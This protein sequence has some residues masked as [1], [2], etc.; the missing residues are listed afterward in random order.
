MTTENR[1]V[2]FEKQGNICIITHNRPEAMN[3]H[4]YQATYEEA[5]AYTEF[6][7]D[8]DLRVAIVTG[9]GDRAFS[10]GGDLKERA[11]DYESFLK[12]GRVHNP[13][14]TLNKPVIAAVNGLAHGG[15]FEEALGCDIIV[16]AEH[17]EF[18]L[19]E[20]LRGIV[21]GAGIHHLPRVMPF[22]QAMSYLLTCKPITAQEAL[23][24]GIVSEVV[25]QRGAHGLRNEMGQRH[26]GVGASG[27]VEHQILRPAGNEHDHRRGNGA[28]QQPVGH[29]VRGRR[30][31]A[32]GLCGEAQARLEGAVGTRWHASLLDT[33]PLLK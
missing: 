6:E 18:R 7:R 11:L 16:A 14:N 25:A 26:P 29:G 31:G 8:P 3:A 23:R 4:N 30:R 5:E 10:A 20:P 33:L 32:K 28:K 21:P 13:L 19:P 24:W 9:T 27:P 2:L 12:R 17:A 22:K 15:G 1:A